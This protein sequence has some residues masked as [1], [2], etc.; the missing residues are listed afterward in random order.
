MKNVVSLKIAQLTRSVEEG[1][2]AWIPTSF[3]TSDVTRLTQDDD[4]PRMDDPVV[5]GTTAGP[6]IRKMLA[7]MGQ[8][9][10]PETFAQ[11]F[12]M[13]RLGVLLNSVAPFVGNS[14]TLATQAAM[15]RRAD[16]HMP[17]VSQLLLCL[18]ERR[19]D[20]AQRWHQEHK[21]LEFWASKYKSLFKEAEQER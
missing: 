9:Q 14:L 17:G 3:D 10:M 12:G 5:W 6:Q 18:R 19:M 21:S 15:L 1:S 11:L 13:Y 20:D 8:S 16:E 7:A 2:I 4:V